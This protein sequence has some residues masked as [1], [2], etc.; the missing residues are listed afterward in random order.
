MTQTPQ[1]R[2]M[3]QEPEHLSLW[4]QVKDHIKARSTSP[5]TTP[6][7]SVTCA[8]CLGELNI[9]GLHAAPPSSDT[10]RSPATLLPCGHMFC[11]ECW[12]S[13][14]SSG[15]ETVKCPTC[16]YSL[17]RTCCGG[18]TE[19][20]NLAHS[21]APLC[22][23]ASSLDFYL[24]KVVP[25]T[26]PE[27]WHDYRGYC[28]PCLELVIERWDITI[29]WLMDE[30]RD[31]GVVTCFE[32]INK[33]PKE[34]AEAMEESARQMDSMTAL[35]KEDEPAWGCTCVVSECSEFAHRNRAVSA[36][37]ALP[38]MSMAKIEV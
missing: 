6:P 21:A 11:V 8:I 13:Y 9:L 4:H 32:L 7:T 35:I 30:C 19:P 24:D 28:R 23:P 22:I 10:P 33:D 31:I 25:K 20:F 17:E 2:T 29:R 36:R 37:L 38:G 34:M 16:R 18:T 3:A 27:G 26:S 15:P 14:G 5:A 1:D 12:G